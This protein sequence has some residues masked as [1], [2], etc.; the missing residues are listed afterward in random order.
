MS[1]ARAARIRLACHFVAG[2]FRPRRVLTFR[3]AE[4]CETVENA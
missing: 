2:E 3:C 4:E 1:L